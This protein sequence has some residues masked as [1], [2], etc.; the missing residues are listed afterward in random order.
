MAIKAVV[1][2]QWGD[3]GKGKIVD[4]LSKDSEIVARYQGGA[5]AGHTV[6]KNDEK[7]VLHQIPSGILRKDCYCI[8][9]NGMV[10]DPLELVD[11]ISM[12]RQKN[13]STDNILISPNAHIVTPL[14]K[15]LD[16]KN[17][18]KTNNFIG[19]TCKG[20]GPCYVDKYNRV[21][22]RALDLN[23]K[24]KL[25][26]AFIS[27]MN[28]CIANHQITDTDYKT[29][30]SEINSFFNAC[31][32]IKIYVKDTLGLLFSK[33]NILIEGAQGTLLDIDHGTYP[34]VTSSSPFSGGITT[35]LGLP[36][37]K[38]ENIIGIF[39]AYATR[40]GSGPFPTELF[41]KD[42]KK[43]QDI[44]M[45]FG[46][47]TG[48]PRRCGWFDGL[49]AKYS[50][51]INGLTDIALTKLDILDSFENIKVCVGYKYNKSEIH[52]YSEA[53]NLE[54]VIP[55][56]KDFKGW[57]CDLNGISDYNMLPLEC[58]EYIKFL[59]DF[60]ETKI[61]IISIGPGRNEI[62]QK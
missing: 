58:K 9:G 48:R 60:L 8:M 47:T 17:E 13:I 55:I 46:A 40:V 38:F 36:L 19:T 61:S 62:I 10:I 23:D 14:H 51:M 7:I 39:K 5:N 42:G 2:G 50:C 54:K 26:T 35:G 22:I 25:R 18:E 49:A 57:N 1:G 59:E 33:K 44:G 12:L 20:I 37:T 15:Y 31:D 4:L 56:Y 30:E 53:V 16:R 24:D 45:E 27:R 34:F 43:L 29:M 3:E 52:N 32:K 11:E 6:Y 41:D 21:G 28:Q